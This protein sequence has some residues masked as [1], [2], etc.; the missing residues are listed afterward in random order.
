MLLALSALALPWLLHALGQTSTSASPAASL[1]YAIAAT[2]L[3]LH[4]R[5]RRHG[6]FGHAAF[7]GLGAYVTGILI[8]EGVQSAGAHLLVTRRR[9]GRWRRW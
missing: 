3:N 6:V 2:S 8:S 5:L 4:A 9:G 7:F 1:I